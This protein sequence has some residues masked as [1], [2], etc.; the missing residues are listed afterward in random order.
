MVEGK[1]GETGEPSRRGDRV[2]NDASREA[3]AARALSL[4]VDAE[5]VVLGQKRESC[6]SASCKLEPCRPPAGLRVLMSYMG[7]SSEACRT[8]TAEAKKTKKEM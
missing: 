5:V 6:G 1:D 8:A 4:E 3:M 7:V 2:T